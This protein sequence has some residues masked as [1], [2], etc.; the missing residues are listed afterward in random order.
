MSESLK[1][2]FG[3]P[4]VIA[5]GVAILTAATGFIAYK[6]ISKKKTE[7]I[8]QLKVLK[9]DT[10]PLDNI[11]NEK[12]LSNLFTLAGQAFDNIIKDGKANEQVALTLY[13]LFK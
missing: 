5:A 2:Y 12:L 3:K 9:V 6:Y 7:M 10:A 13:S 11:K 8:N 4:M 1:Q